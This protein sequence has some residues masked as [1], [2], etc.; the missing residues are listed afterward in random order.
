MKLYVFQEEVNVSLI[1]WCIDFVNGVNSGEFRFASV[2]MVLI[3]ECDFTKKKGECNPVNTDIY[4]V[5]CTL[6]V[7]TVTMALKHFLIT[8]K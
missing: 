1:K 6:E 3:L 2:I 8:Y 5:H 4:V 7:F